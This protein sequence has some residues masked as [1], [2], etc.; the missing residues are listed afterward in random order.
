MGSSPLMRD[1]SFRHFSY[2][3]NTDYLSGTTVIRTTLNGPSNSP[4]RS[5]ELLL[6]ERWGKIAALVRQI[7]N[8]SG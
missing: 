5:V 7:H 1:E 4:M 6:T 8:M 2:E 3:R